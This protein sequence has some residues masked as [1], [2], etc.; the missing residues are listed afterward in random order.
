MRVVTLRLYDE[1][2]EEL[3]RVAAECGVSAG[4]LLRCALRYG[5][6]VLG[7][8]IDVLTG[9]DEGC[10]RVKS[11]RSRVHASRGVARRG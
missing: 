11:C 1:A 7:V 6:L 10:V 8:D 4:E 3:K 9:K 2:W 5:L